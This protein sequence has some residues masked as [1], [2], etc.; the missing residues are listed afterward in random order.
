MREMNMTGTCLAIIMEKDLISFL[1][2]FC[3]QITTQ[4]RKDDKETAERTLDR[5]VIILVD[6]F[7]KF[8]AHYS[9]EFSTKRFWHI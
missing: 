7:H 5:N 4:H 3:T 1:A 2:H 8:P 6:F 9:G